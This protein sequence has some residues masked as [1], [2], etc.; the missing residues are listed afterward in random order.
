MTLP[1]DER[2][3]MELPVQPYI[4]LTL[5]EAAAFAADEGRHVRVLTSLAG[6]RRLDVMPSRVNVELDDAVRVVGADAG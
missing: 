6:P 1:D 3:L 2:R 4:G 5:A